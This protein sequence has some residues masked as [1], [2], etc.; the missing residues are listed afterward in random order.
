MKKMVDLVISPHSPELDRLL[1]R[2]SRG[3]VLTDKEWVNLHDSVEHVYEEA[4]RDRSDKAVA[5]A[6]LLAYVECKRTSLKMM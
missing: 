6:F 5:T 4:I 2:L 3:D 1:L